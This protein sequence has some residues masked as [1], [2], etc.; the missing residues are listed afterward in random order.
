MHDLAFPFGQAD[1][2]QDV[3][4]P[5]RMNSGTAAGGPGDVAHDGGRADLTTGLVGE[6]TGIAG[7]SL[8]G[9]Q[10][11][12]PVLFGDDRS[13]EAGRGNDVEPGE[14]AGGVDHSLA[15]GDAADGVGGAVTL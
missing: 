8:G 15:E 4:E 11:G 10:F 7:L 3:A 2:L 5:H 9:F 1:R 14:D 6:E 13:G 12:C